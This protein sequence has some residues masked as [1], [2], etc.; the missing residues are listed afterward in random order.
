MNFLQEELKKLIGNAKF[1]S[2]KTFIGHVA[3]AKINENIRVRIEFV[4]ISSPS[5]YDSI[6]VYIIEIS[7]NSDI[8]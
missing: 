7:P 4:H 8:V 5:N 3:F 6:R 1:I 2:E